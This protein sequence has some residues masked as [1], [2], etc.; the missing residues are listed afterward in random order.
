M[1]DWKTV[2]RIQCITL[3]NLRASTIIYR[4]SGNALYTANKIRRKFHIGHLGITRMKSLMYCST[5]WLRMDQDIEKII[6]ECRGCRLL[7]KAP[8]IKTQPWLKTDFPWI[9]LHIDYAEPLNGHY[10]L[11]I[12]DSFSKWREIFKCRH[13]TSTNIV[14]ALNE[15]F[16]HFST[17]QR[18]TIY[19]QRI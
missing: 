10:Y 15:L 9:R 6:K 5:Y 8:S 14:N 12:V 3:F 16:R 7:A 19:Q 4:E 1:A 11:I 13:S 17:R 2:N 18:D